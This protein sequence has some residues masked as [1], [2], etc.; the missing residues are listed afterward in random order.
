[1]T[2]SQRNL[3]GATPAAKTKAKPLPKQVPLPAAPAIK[4][5]PQ[6]ELQRARNLASVRN[7]RARMRVG[8]LRLSDEPCLKCGGQ[9]IGEVVGIEP[10]GGITWEWRCTECSVS[11]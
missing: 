5:T 1:M 2:D 3:F 8:E 6:L 7:E 11:P 9:R 10:Q 4:L